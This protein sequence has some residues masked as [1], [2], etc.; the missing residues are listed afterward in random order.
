M[1][2][3]Q[4][5]KIS[6]VILLLIWV[7][8][9]YFFLQRTVDFFKY[10]YQNNS[11]QISNK[12]IFSTKKVQKTMD[13]IRKESYGFSSKSNIQIEDAVLKSIVYGLGDKHSTYF[14]K[15][16]TSDFTE[17]LRW[18][19]EW[20]WA[21]INQVQSGI[22]I[23]RIISWSPAEK[24]WLKNWD[25]M[26]KVGDT[27]IV[28]KT[29]EEAIVSIRWPKWTQAIISY[30]RWN[31]PKEYSVTVT[32]DRVRIPSVEWKI[33]E[34][35]IGYIEIAT[36]G[37]NTTKEFTQIW[38][39][40]TTSGAQAMILDF[41]NNGWWYL[42]TAVDLASL[43]L[44][45][46]TPVVIIK[47][48]DV[49]KNETLLTKSAIANTKI[50][51]ILL[52]NEFSASASEILAGALQDHNRAIILGQK[53]Y[54][55]W[56]VQEPFDLWDESIIKIT[57]ARWYTPK[58]ISIDEKWIKPDISVAFISKDFDTVFD[59]QLKAAEIIMKDA[60]ENK[61]T[62]D[63]LKQKYIPYN[64]SLLNL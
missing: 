52:I 19:F 29:T 15:K 40:L 23:V 49:R 17:S 47:Q 62:V 39:T 35:N 20:I 43:V 27:S 18:D 26:T 56:S 37:E 28:W 22:K 48:N 45:Q 5:Y 46:N 21:V 10:S 31:D 41:R 9:W 34:S 14:T 2:F 4:K 42:N 8:F 54:G 6:P 12:D 13:I 57:T 59:R 24:V 1:S 3:S 25:I 38:N 58:D 55:K 32:R 60:I 30:I 53:S 50:P 16:E 61:S 11:T 44:P 33:L 7:L 51:I 63:I 64:F 36:F